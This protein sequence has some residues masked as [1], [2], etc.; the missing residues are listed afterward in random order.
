M[1]QTQVI[2]FDGLELRFSPRPSP[3]AQQRRLQIDAHF[4]CLRDRNPHL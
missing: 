1:T 4:A 3:F 2:G